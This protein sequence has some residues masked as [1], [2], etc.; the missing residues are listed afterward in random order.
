MLAAIEDLLT[1]HVSRRDAFRA[2]WQAVSNYTTN[3]SSV[4]RCTTEEST[5]AGLSA[6]SRRW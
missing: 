5:C 1:S 3:G 4:N 2:I 6:R